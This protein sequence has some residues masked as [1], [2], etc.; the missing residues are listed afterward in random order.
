MRSDYRGVNI[1]C[2]SITRSIETIESFSAGGGGRLVAEVSGTFDL[3]A[4]VR[5]FEYVILP[6]CR[7][8][9]LTQVMI[10]LARF[11]IREKDHPSRFVGSVNSY[12]IERDRESRV[13]GRSDTTSGVR[14]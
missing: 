7:S 6:A 10:E 14:D 1:Q 3:D 13:F 12:V 5:R 2:R 4:A 9:N 11:R 8:H